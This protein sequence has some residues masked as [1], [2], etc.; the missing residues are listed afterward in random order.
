MYRK[1]LVTMTVTVV[2]SVGIQLVSF[3]A[4]FFIGLAMGAP[5]A[6]KHYLVF[7]PIIAVMTM[8]PVIIG[9]LGV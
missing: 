2:F 6:L 4:V 1:N 9:G 3:I 8:L 5:A 7:I